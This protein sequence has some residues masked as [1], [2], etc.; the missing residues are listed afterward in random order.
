MTM[1]MTMRSLAPQAPLPSS[2]LLFSAYP[3]R[4]P[5]VR[6]EAGEVYFGR[7]KDAEAGD[8]E[9][10]FL[11]LADGRT[12][13]AEI[14]G[15]RPHLLAAAGA[16][17]HAVWLSSPL[18]A[19][20]LPAG[21]PRSL[22]LAAHP[23][24]VE[25][26]MGGLVLRR[27]HAGRFTLLNCFSRQL[28][29]RSPEAFG[30]RQEVTAIRRDESW[31][32]ATVLGTE[33]RYLDFPELALRRQGAA[34]ERVTLPAGELATAVKLALHDAI[35]ELA[36][37]HVYAPAAAGESPDQRMIFDAVLDLYEEDYFPATRYHFY[38]NVPLAASY[39]NVDDFLSRFEGS[40]LGLAPW[41]EEID[42]VLAEKL[43]LLE[44]FRS[45][46]DFGSRRLLAEM[47]RRNAHLARR[48]ADCAERFWTLRDAPPRE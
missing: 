47:G 41:F 22:L 42:G 46:L 45:R 16:S 29:T 17:R 18:A 44:I 4:L 9:R 28:A 32:A 6:I 20:Q 31:L 37:E 38:E 21:G 23:G 12:P 8:A 36:A 2:R 5:H 14:F 34:G 26:S 35:D 27:R 11:A 25:L 15:L 30:S 39:L 19:P 10:E 24:D 3:C 1:T 40:Y 7:L 33:T 43:T 48:G 13:F